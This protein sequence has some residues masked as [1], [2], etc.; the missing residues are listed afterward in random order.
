MRELAARAMFLA[1]ARFEGFPRV[2][3]AD[4]GVYELIDCHLRCAGENDLCII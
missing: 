2:M 4:H 1:Y 3:G